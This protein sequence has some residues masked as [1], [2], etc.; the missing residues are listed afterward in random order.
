ML[1]GV[2]VVLLGGAVWMGT[3]TARA[4][5]ATK[6]IRLG[7]AFTRQFAVYGHDH[8]CAGA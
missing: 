5:E 1:V 3:A 8:L 6:G 7:V 4:A 2:L